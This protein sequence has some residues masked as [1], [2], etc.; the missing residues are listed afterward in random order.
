MLEIEIDMSVDIFQ[1]VIKDGKAEEERPL[2][3]EDKKKKADEEAAKLKELQEID[4][5]T[6]D[7]QILVH[8]IEARDLKV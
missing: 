5:K 2:S 4:I 6:G 1:I 8:V 7:Y 3:E